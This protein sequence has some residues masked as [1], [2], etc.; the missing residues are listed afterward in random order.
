MAKRAGRFHMTAQALIARLNELTGQS[1]G[2]FQGVLA[3]LRKI[4]DVRLANI[5][6]R[7]TPALLLLES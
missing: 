2:H 1:P 3:G 7:D 5:T 6:D 4:G